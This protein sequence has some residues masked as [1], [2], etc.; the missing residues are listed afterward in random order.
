MYVYKLIK[1]WNWKVFV[2]CLK[3]VC[4]LHFS[5]C[6]I[7]GTPFPHPSSPCRHLPYA[8]WMLA[9]SLGL[10][11]Y[12]YDLLLHLLIHMPYAPLPAPFMTA[13]P[14][15]YIC[16]WNFLIAI[17]RG[18]ESERG[19]WQWQWDRIGPERTLMNKYRMLL[20]SLKHSEWD[21]NKGCIPWQ[22]AETETE[23]GGGGGKD[24]N[25]RICM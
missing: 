21:R 22:P 11:T 5:H 14:A 20:R 8:N 1:Y 3:T 12:E 16:I 10:A 13:I 25:C 18:G 6:S 4:C 15:G 7:V 23:R 2:L 9:R 24:S 17:E 19:G